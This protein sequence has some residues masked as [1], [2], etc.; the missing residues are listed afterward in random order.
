MYMN[1]LIYDS[2]LVGSYTTDWSNDYYSGTL[3]CWQKCW[4]TNS[5]IVNSQFFIKYFVQKNENLLYKIY[6]TNTHEMKY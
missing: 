6:T 5:Q 3:I 1:H 4:N 2:Q